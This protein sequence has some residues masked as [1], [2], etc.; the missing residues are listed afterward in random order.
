[1]HVYNDTSRLE[2]L[3]NTIDPF[4]FGRLGPSVDI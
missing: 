1:M 4:L 2:Q 3:I